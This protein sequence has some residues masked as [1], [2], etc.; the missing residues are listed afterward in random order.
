LLIDVGGRLILNFNDAGD[1]GWGGFVK[2]ISRDY[3]IR[4]LLKLGG[5]GDADMINLFEE[6][7]SRIVPR[8]REGERLGSV[9]AVEAALWGARFVVPFS[10]MH[11]YQ[12]ADSVWANPYTADAEDYRAGFESK[13]SELLP[14]FIR[15]DCVKDSTE[16]L[17]PSEKSIQVRASEEYGDNWKDLLTTD[18]VRI[19]RQYFG[20]VAHLHEHYDFLN[21]RVGGRDNMIELSTRKFDRGITFE[22]PR[23]SLMTAVQYE[24][25]DDL[26]IGNFMKTTLHGRF[27]EERLYPHFTPYVAKYGDNG[28]ART[29]EE[30][31]AYFRAYRR[32]APVDY[33]RHVLESSSRHAVMAILRTDSPAYR[34]ISRLYH[35]ITAA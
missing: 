25:F 22:V 8:S 26:L 35:F 19:L 7:G 16:A 21:I 33:F 13:T 24:V 29:H 27:G 14:A 15:Y 5:F 18:D 34:T 11:K 31:E 20:S 23:T 3:P 9:M 17:H 30:L 10:S 12:R 32:R 4:F 6:N 28:K 2:A 1:R